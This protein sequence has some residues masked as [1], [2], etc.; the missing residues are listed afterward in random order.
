MYT[1]KKINGGDAVEH[2]MFTFFLFTVDD[3][4]EAFIIFA[5][6]VNRVVES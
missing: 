2:S 1:K 5:I 6:S 3:S 4:I